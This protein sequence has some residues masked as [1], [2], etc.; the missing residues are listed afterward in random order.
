MLKPSPTRIISL[1]STFKNIC[2]HF[3]AVL[4]LLILYNQ[5]L[6][7]SE[8]ITFS[9]SI[10]AHHSYFLTRESTAMILRRFTYGNLCYEMYFLQVIKFGHLSG[11]MTRPKSH[12]EDQF[13]GLIGSVL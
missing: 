6:E 5:H 2:E 4:V 13:E 7:H 1:I 12:A 8:P 9:E 11:T 10:L 3:D